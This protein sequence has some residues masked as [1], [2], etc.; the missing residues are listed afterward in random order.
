MATLAEKLEKIK[1]PKL[2]NQHHT[3]VV[4]SA[5]E[6]TLRDQKADF[7]PTAY[8]AALLALLSQSIS[9][10]QG[11]VN[12]DL[13][14]SVVYL[15]DLTTAYVPASIL[16][17]KF[18]QI[19]TGL[20]PALSL[21]EVDAPLLR[22][23]IGCLE[24][25]LVAQDVA[26]WNL[27]HTQIGPRRAIAGLLS[28]AVDHRPKVRK[29]AQ[30]ALV[31]VL[32][33]PPPS[34]SLDHP[35]ADMCAE[36]AMRTLSDS[37]TAAAK[38]KRGRHDS[39]GRDT[40]DPLVIHSLQLV[41]TLAV[42]SGGWPSKKIEPLC[43]LLMN[44]SRSTNE[45][46]TMGAFEVFEV[47]F[48]SMADEFSSS[49][50]P[51]LLEAIT[52]LKPAQNDSQLL[53]PWIAVL[54]RGYDVS[55][56][57]SPEDTFEK[58]PALFNM[59]SGY[60][61]SPSSNIRVSASECLVSFLANC[62]PNS[63]II[64]PSVYDEKTLEKIAKAAM[65]LLSV[66]Y[67]AAWREVFNVCAALFDSFKW[68]SSPFLDDIV[69]TVGEL[70][71]NESFQGKKEADNVL[72]SAIE[73]MG[74]AAV[75]EI[76]P[77][78]IIEQK[79]GQPG[80]VWLLPVLRDNVT[81]T[82][83]AHF[84][85]EFVP[86]SEALYQK[87][88]EFSARE[89]AVE[90]KI[91][92]TL[93][94]Q[95]W[96]ILPGYCELPLDLTESFD[97]S[98]AELLSNVLYKQTDLRVDI[99]RALQNLVESNQAI[100]SVEADEDDLILQRRI[101][102]KAAEKNVAHLAGFASNLLAVLFN[103][104]SQTLPH[105]RGYILQCINAYLSIAPE[106]EL[107]ET[108]ERVTSMLESSVVSETETAKQGNQ[109]T[110]SGDKMPPTSHTLI[111]LV[112]AMSIYLPRTSFANL[113]GIAAAI[114]N[115]QTGDQQLIKKAYK[116]IPRLAQTETGSA[117]LQ[118]RSSELQALI[119]GTA[120][121]TPASARRDRM[122]AI[123]ELI[124]YLP[125]SDLHFIPSVLSE[126]VLGC[127]ESNEKART[128]SFDLL[129]HLAKRTT[130]EEKNPAGT[131]I[132][133]SLV[134]HMPND[135]PDAPATIEE[136]FTMV[137]AGLAGSSPHMVAASVTALSR[138]FFDFHTQIQPTVR[139]DLVQTVEL[140]LTS[141]N[142]EIVRS[143]LGFVKVAVVVL[144]DEDLRARL[145]SLVPNL[146]VWSKEHKGRLRSKVKGILD[147]LIRRFGAAPI[148][149]L[150]G[151]ADRKLV[152]NIRKLRERRK[153]KKNAE[154]DGE[155]DEEN[156]EPAGQEEKSGRSY[157]NA[158]DKAVYDSDLDSDDDASEIDVDEEGV[159]HALKGR[160][161]KRSNK[162]SEQYIREMSPED[163]PL[164]LLAPDA[165]ANISTTKPSVRFLNTGPGSRK[166]R[167]AKVDSD[168][169]LILGDDDE[170]V[171]MS[172]GLDNNAGES[173]I[174]AYVQAVSGPDAVRRGQRGKLKMA[175][176]QKKKGGDDMDVDDDNDNNASG[177]ASRPGPGRRGLGMPKTHGPSGAGRIQKRMPMRGRPGR[178]GSR[179]G[180][181]GGGRG[182]GFRVGGN[183]R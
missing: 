80:R 158:F 42:A 168:G 72:G 93:V 141:N 134:P 41:K 35:A 133:N 102:K 144:P 179:G 119:L 101:T 8:F 127:K 12:K 173:G 30:D 100:L 58:L 88:M 143:V 138:L 21:P 39:S 86:L 13:A 16:R 43:E 162:Q 23:S 108:F 81:N 34:P 15:L 5:V 147:R 37:I 117:A 66:K 92:E 76:L 74:P 172:A 40:H 130:D 82:D 161:G 175:Q 55:A 146:M 106:K 36:T 90:V 9:A 182:G 170:D 115:G 10:T 22:P 63:V 65:D 105:Y 84:R 68:R 125:T 171:D 183:R 136:F 178:G 154:Q 155:D 159:T 126:V 4:L 94:Q 129:I 73:A 109:Q 87:V 96:A 103:V 116:L 165:L 112:I 17:A 91:F 27:P 164:D 64:E 110:G 75:L 140:F 6:D 95:T 47:I 46:I 132:R 180:S 128:A 49:K 53:P 45:F 28:L 153:K 142:R 24:S 7:S 85:S 166:K 148:E 31:K 70:R 67:Q 137:S 156:D 32:K 59:V 157:S 121:K 18:S 61:A 71:S 124:T 151:E 118:E 60:L 152:V 122:L 69:K 160:K 163:N 25:L 14:T 98:F 177:P 26:A 38:S 50:L 167:N 150:V 135:A 54:S 139:S 97:Q 176:S 48:S 114:L 2:Q 33:S 104:Y 62:I 19:L 52:D 145:S 79:N 131:K 77:L 83:L 111:D 89:K 11:I 123:Y 44:A 20:A 1:S 99:C 78:N 56:Q 51:R 149:E 3:A 29:R 181:R 57:T 113:F 169:R 107:N 120:D 174:N